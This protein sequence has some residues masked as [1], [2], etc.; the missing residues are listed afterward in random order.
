MGAHIN[1]LEA[2]AKKM[3]EMFNK[4]IKNR[5]LAMNTIISKIKNTLEGYNSRYLR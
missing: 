4:E 5:L 1:R 2:W 3:Q